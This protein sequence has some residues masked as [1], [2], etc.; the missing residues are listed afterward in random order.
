MAYKVGGTKCKKKLYQMPFMRHIDNKPVVRFTNYDNYGRREALKK[1]LDASYLKHQLDVEEDMEQLESDPMTSRF[2]AANQSSYSRAMDH[3]MKTFVT[4][5]QEL[6]NLDLRGQSDP[7]PEVFL[8]NL[9]SAAI[10]GL[11]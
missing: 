9:N 3:V 5:E 1:F 7:K 11:L 4:R 10:P 8:E 2:L 6:S